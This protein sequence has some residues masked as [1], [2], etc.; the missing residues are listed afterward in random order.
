ML[1]T[2]LI[3]PQSEKRIDDF[4]AVDDLAVLH[5]FCEQNAASSLFGG[6]KDQR[7]P[8]RDTVDTMKIDS[9]EHA[10]Y[11]GFDY[12]ELC[13][14]RYLTLCQ[15]DVQGEYFR[16]RSVV[17]LQNLYRYHAGPQSHVML[18]QVGSSRLFG[19]YF[20]VVRIHK[21]VGVKKRPRTPCGKRH[22]R[23]HLSRSSYSSSRFHFQSPEFHCPA[24][25]LRNS[26]S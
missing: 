26:M 23:G 12:V 22:F 21:D 4:D 17:L 7:I 5:V 3:L 18:N 14:H 9:A 19:R 10:I 8:K 13:V 1:I 24:V 6:L 16:N 25:L 20:G 15:S 11:F 2:L